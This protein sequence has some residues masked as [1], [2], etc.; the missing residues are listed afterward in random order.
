MHI[1]QLVAMDAVVKTGGFSSAARELNKVPSA[2]SYNIKSLEDELGL[3]LF[4]RDGYRAQLTEQGQAIHRAAQSMLIGAKNLSTLAQEMNL[5]VEPLL[6]LDVTPIVD[7]DVLLPVF[8][9][10]HAQFPATRLDISMEVFGGEALVLEDRVEI[11]ISEMIAVDDQLDS[12]KFDQ[13]R[14]LAV[15]AP[16]HTLSKM[17]ALR[18]SDLLN[19][20]QI[21]VESRLSKWKATTLGVA[22]GAHIWRVTD[23]AIKKNFIMNGI[24]WGNMPSHLV[25]REI[26]RGQLVALDIRANEMMSDVALVRHKHHALGPAG[27]FLW[28]S[29]IELSASPEI[30]G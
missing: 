19:H 8:D 28:A 17:S 1:D 21:V 29:L 15:A 2:V 10:F 5:G 7:F 12:V 13:T 11:S 24:G 27:R 18:Q 25:R 4:D 9:R 6:R 14:F 20:L 26:E 30:Q 22:Q 16:G 3:V 23:F